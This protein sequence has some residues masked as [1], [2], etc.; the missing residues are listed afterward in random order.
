MKLNRK[1]EMEW[2]LKNIDFWIDELSHCFGR[3]Q[4]PTIFKL[5]NVSRRKAPSQMS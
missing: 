2:K 1:F 3:V 4:L 5:A